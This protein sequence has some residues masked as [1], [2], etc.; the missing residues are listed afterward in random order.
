VNLRVW[1]VQ[2]VGQRTLEMPYPPLA[3]RDPECRR[4]GQR[5][6]RRRGPIL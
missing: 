5:R 6:A 2:A 1:Q 4:K 3:G